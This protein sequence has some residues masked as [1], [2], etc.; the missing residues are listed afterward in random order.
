MK[1]T[2]R[3]FFKGSLLLG[4]SLLFPP[5]SLRAKE[6]PREPWYPAYG[7]LE[8]ARGLLVTSEYLSACCR[9][10][11]KNRKYK[12]DVTVMADEGSLVF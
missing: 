11:H 8:K 6:P 10:K 12:I 2:R 7:K 1:F 4:G 3:E 9:H 5:I